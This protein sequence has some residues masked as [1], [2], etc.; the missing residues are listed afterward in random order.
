MISAWRSEPRKGTAMAENEKENTVLKGDREGFLSSRV[1]NF[2]MQRY[3]LLC[4]RGHALRAFVMTY[5]Q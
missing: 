4:R 3:S 2:F 1:P 5:R